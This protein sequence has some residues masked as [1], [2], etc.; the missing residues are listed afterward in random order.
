MV[1]TDYRA[2]LKLPE[3]LRPESLVE[4]HVHVSADGILLFCIILS[5]LHYII[6]KCCRAFLFRELFF[7]RLT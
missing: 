2:K 1:L 3:I 4:E 6:A 7:C 5:I